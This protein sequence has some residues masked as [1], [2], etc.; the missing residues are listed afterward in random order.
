MD[1]LEYLDTK[2]MRSVFWDYTVVER[3]MSRIEGLMQ[4][5]IPTIKRY[6]YHAWELKPERHDIVVNIGREIS[7]I[8]YDDILG[9]YRNDT[10]DYNE[11]VT[12]TPS[13]MVGNIDQSTTNGNLLVERIRRAGL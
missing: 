6:G 1:M 9:I 3:V 5:L 11:I 2:V 10:I 7:A 13:T 8:R 12:E 4:K